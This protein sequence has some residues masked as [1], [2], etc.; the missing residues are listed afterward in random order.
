MLK[1]YGKILFGPHDFFSILAGVF[2]WIV[3]AGFLVLPAS[4]PEI[5]NLVNKSG[6]IS[7]IVRFMRNIPLYVLLFPLI[8]LFD[9]QNG[10]SCSF[11]NI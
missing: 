6:E 7:K 10:C 1:E 8:P 4:F 9:P 3:L 2:M 5:Q 11:S